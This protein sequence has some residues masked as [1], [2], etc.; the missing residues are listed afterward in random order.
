VLDV[1][2]HDGRFS[3]GALL[4]GAR[5]VVGVDHDPQLVA[6]A[7]AHFEH[8]GID[9]AGYRFECRDLFTSFLDLGHFDVVLCFGILYHVNDHLHLLS[10]IAELEPRTVIIDGHV[11]SHD[12]AVIELRTP[13]GE[14]PPPPGSQLEGWPSP[15]AIEAL[16]ATLGW[17][18]DWIDW[19]AVAGPDDEGIGDYLSGKRRSF[20]ATC[21]DPIPE[22]TRELAVGLVFEAQ[23]EPRFQWHAITGISRHFGINPQALRVWVRKAEREGRR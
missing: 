4:T 14:S 17:A 22:E 1:A 12:A 8:Q 20:V 2:S 6:A 19:R 10:N 18:G 11:S 15:A 7:T 5:E 9:P 21:P 23:Q 13:L 3:L 16:T